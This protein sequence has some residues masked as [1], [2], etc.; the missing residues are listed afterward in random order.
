VLISFIVNV[1]IYIVRGSQELEPWIVLILGTAISIA[2]I[3]IAHYF[4][5]WRERGKKDEK[6]S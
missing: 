3:V 1:L 5:K 6:I 2:S 4:R